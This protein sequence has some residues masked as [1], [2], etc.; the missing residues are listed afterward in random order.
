MGSNTL[1]LRAVTVKCGEGYAGTNERQAHPELAEDATPAAM[2]GAC[3]ELT[4]CSTPIAK[5]M[6]FVVV[7]FPVCG[8]MEVGLWFK[9]EGKFKTEKTG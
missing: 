9:M 6:Q 5:T 8:Q 1:H 3:S 7:V 4:R 2:C